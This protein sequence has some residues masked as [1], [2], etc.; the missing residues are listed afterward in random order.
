MEWLCLLAEIALQRELELLIDLIVPHSN[1]DARKE[2]AFSMAH[3]EY[4]LVLATL[5][6]LYQERFE[7]P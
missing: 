5:S 6:E 1:S 3:G 7:T 4:G 2:L